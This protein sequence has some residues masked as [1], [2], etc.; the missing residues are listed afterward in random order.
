MEEWNKL[1]KNY[2]EKYP[3]E[4][5]EI[6]RMFKRDVKKEVFESLEEL[7]KKAKEKADSTRAHSGAMLNGIKSH[8]PEL[9]RALL[10]FF[11]S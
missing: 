1:F 5:A 11:H 10:S 4:A 2:K 9:V 8:M 3:T 7:G 6:E